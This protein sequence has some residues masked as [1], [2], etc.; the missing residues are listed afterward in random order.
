MSGTTGI[1][2]VADNKPILLEF[3]AVGFA[4]SGSQ[5]SLFLQT[6]TTGRI[7]AAL[8]EVFTVLDCV[9][10]SREAGTTGAHMIAY[11]VP[12]E[13]FNPEDLCLDRLM[14]GFT[15]SLS[16]VAI[17]AIPLTRTGAV[18]WMALEHLAVLD[19][20]LLQ[21]WECR[22]GASS[23]ISDVAVLA[24]AHVP[25]LPPLHLADVLPDWSARTVPGVATPVV[26]SA[27]PM[28]VVQVPAFRDGGVLA[29]DSP[30]TLPEL[31]AWAADIAPEQGITYLL[32]D[33]SEQTQTYPQ[34]WEEA[35]RI[36]RGLQSLG[37]EPQNPVLLQLE[38][39]Q[40]LIP[41]FWGCLL[42]GFVPLI[43]PLPPTFEQPNSALDKLIH[44]WR[45]L[46]QPWVLTTQAAVSLAL[47]QARLAL[48]EDLRVHPLA[49]DFHR[50]QPDAVAMFNLTSGSTG[51]PK[52]IML[53]HQNLIS[54]AR[55]TNLLCGHSPEDI[56][57]NWLPFDHIG[58]I[59]DWH[60]RC[61]AL[62][63][64]MVYVPKERVL[65]EPL[66]WLELLDRYR[67]SHSWA[68]NFAYALIN[69]A[70]KQ[71]GTHAWD[72]TCVKT[73]LSAGEAVAPQTVSEFLAN[74]ARWGLKPTVM[75]PAFGMAELGSGI[76]YFQP[77]PE[78]PLVYHTVDKTALSPGAPLVRIS[79]GASTAL[80]FVD[81]GPPIP[82]VSLRIVDREHNVLP[83]DTVG[84]LHIQGAVVFRGYYRN[85]EASQ[86]VLLADGWFD[87]GDLGFLAQGHLVVVGRQKESIILNGA[88]YYSHDIEQ[89]V[90]AVAGVEVSFTA[91]CAV[92]DAGQV[93]DRLAIFFVPNARVDLVHVLHAIRQRLGQGAGV[94][95]DYLLP[96][97]KTAIP[98]TGI[99]K[100]QRGQLKQRFEA[101]EFSE[102]LKRVD[103][104]LGN[105]N[106]VGDWFYR[107]VWQ[108][109][110]PP[111]VQP[112]E[113]AAISGEPRAL[114]P[115]PRAG[116]T[117][118]FVDELGLGAF[119]GERLSAVVW[120]QPGAEFLRRDAGHFCIHPAVPEHYHRLLETLDREG[121][122]IHR[123]VHCW[124]Y[125]DIPA[126]I[127]DLD[128]TRGLKSLLALTQALAQE[129]RQRVELFVVSKNI[130]PVLPSDPLNWPHS[131]LLGL[132]HTIGQEL[133]GLDCRHIDLPTEALAVNGAWVLREL[134]LVSRDREVAYRQG[135]RRVARLQR[136]DLVAEPKQSVPLQPKGMYL[137]SG[138]LGGVGLEVAK[139]LLQH[140]QA[141]LILVGRTE[142]LGERLEALE[143]LKGLGEVVY[144]ALD[145]AN[146]NALREATERAKVRWGCPLDGVLHLAGVYQEHLLVEETPETLQAV[147]H[148][149]LQGTWALHQLLTEQ[150]QPGLFVSFSS[151]CGA[152]GGAMVGAY[153]A[154]HSFLDTFVHYQRA[155]GLPQSY[156]LSWSLWD[157]VG[158]GR[159]Y[160]WKTALLSRGYQPLSVRQGLQ[161]LLIGLSQANPHL[162]IG[163][164]GRNPLLRA[165]CLGDL[166]P[167]QQVYAYYSPLGI[168]LL[169]ESME[170][171]FGTPI[172]L[173]PV[174]V[175]EIPRYPDGRVKVRALLERA[176]APVDRKQTPTL[177]HSHVERTMAQI[178]QEV[179]QLDRVG[180]NDSFFDL[181]GHSI[182]MAQVQVRLREVLQREVT[183]LDMFTYPTISALTKFLNRG[184]EDPPAFAPSQE[185]AT[186]RRQTVQQQRRL[187]QQHRATREGER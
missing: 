43:L 114:S 155:V 159:D 166:H 45:F 183:L 146:L 5:G 83:E 82:G 161:A 145:C 7:E 73:L 69:Q 104:L 178:W 14:P 60:L 139:Y 153:A 110:S 59:S 96:V 80:T 30:Q 167:L 177:P 50:P 147:L 21:Q 156:C 22:L 9:V 125:E 172:R 44:T 36:L 71:P 182:L 121:I 63:C 70:L 141:R 87:T 173:V 64:R 181:G 58:S 103:I 150:P 134:T 74:L 170:D 164:D 138:G 28:S 123:V 101:G 124:T 57:L 79:A 129:E 90:E 4:G 186:T 3:E 40:D 6:P 39:H 144:E 140:Y 126:P 116:H 38:A 49:T 81:L 100:I 84:A 32:A 15:C 23:G 88:N 31:L 113:T 169:A 185:R 35:R 25:V 180:V 47:P 165:H 56:I 54:R 135:E 176:S 55:G 168:P 76:T 52:C 97:A 77:T 133:P 119:V 92:R 72:L 148:P 68:P 130:Q 143:G 174:A 118:I 20:A 51:M 1:G 137:L 115:P 18:D 107:K 41:A 13:T 152:R 171:R 99:G 42:G 109:F 102:A 91:A 33:G 48:L 120:V 78:E 131:T 93:S 10:V 27:V 67:I 179:L 162:L 19:A 24:Q 108:I 106:T 157:E 122:A 12:T 175:P 111:L 66:Y 46:D 8:R 154:A 53:T 29:P 184:A 112:H 75:Q 136:V 105:Q 128:Q 89:V 26:S 17:S 86:A 98:K 94:Q 16:F 2:F 149:K 85:P 158:L 160:P 187:R 62:G 95:A 132:M 127:P 37:L 163:L 61:V 142:A 151:V 34:L 65:G 117:L 11:V